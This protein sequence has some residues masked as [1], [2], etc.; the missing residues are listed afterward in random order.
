MIKKEDSCVSCPFL[1]TN[2]KCMQIFLSVCKSCINPPNSCRS[3]QS[4]ELVSRPL[5]QPSFLGTGADHQESEVGEDDSRWVLTDDR[6]VCLQ[7]FPNT[8]LGACPWEHACSPCKLKF[9]CLRFHAILK[10][11]SRLFWK[12]C[13]T[14]PCV[15]G[16]V[17]LSVVIM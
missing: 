6:K 12:V 4:Q 17:S 14:T 13:T 5:K 1:L 11:L 16:H 7:V 15:G 3:T 8:A 9:L 2:L 10:V